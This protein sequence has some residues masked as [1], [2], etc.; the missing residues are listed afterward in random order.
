MKME[1]LVTD[2]WRG[3]RR[4]IRPN[5]KGS[6]VLGTTN[7]NINKKKLK[8]PLDSVEKERTVEGLKI[9]L[10]AILLTHS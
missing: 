2:S 7:N 1:M 4:E 9:I 8:K 3:F 6:L 5:G 10:N